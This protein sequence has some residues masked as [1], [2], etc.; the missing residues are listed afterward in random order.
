MSLVLITGEEH[1]DDHSLMHYRTKGSKNG[2]RRFQNE[3]GSLTPEG[4]IHYGVGEGKMSRDSLE[5]E[6]AKDAEKRQRKIEKTGRK[7]ERTSKRITKNTDA[8]EEFR[9]KSEKNE[10]KAN[11]F[12]GKAEAQAMRTALKN[13][14]SIDEARRM[15]MESAKYEQFIHRHSRAL[16]Y[17]HY[18][19]KFRK[20]AERGEKKLAKYRARLMALTPEDRKEELE[21]AGLGDNFFEMLDTLSEKQKAALYVILDDILPDDEE[22]DLNHSDDVLEGVDRCHRHLMHYRTKGSKN[23]VRRYQYEDGSL[24][25]EGRIHYGVGEGRKDGSGE[26]EDVEKKTQESINSFKERRKAKAAEREERKKQAEEERKAARDMSDA[27]LNARIDRLQREKRYADLL[28]ERNAREQSEFSKTVHKLI[29]GAAED[30]A[31]KSLTLVVNKMIDKAKEG[32][33]KD[34]VIDLSEYKDVDIYSLKSDKIAAIAGAFQQ[35]AQLAQNR[36][37][38]ANNGNDQNNQNG[39]NSQNNQGNKNNQNNQG[40]KDNSSD[41]AKQEGQNNEGATVSK[42]QRKK[43][44][45]LASSGMS[46]SEIAEKLGVSES[47]VRQYA[48]E[49]LKKEEEQRT[50]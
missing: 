39:S 19:E 9:K 30:L 13:H 4:R 1:A 21:H 50:A 2:I 31:K 18:S 12:L 7:I 38:I 8:A 41:K 23:G 17:S 44:R 26:E 35:A 14:T 34:S 22:G 5:T 27:D 16:A 29:S 24:T 10:Q 3:D 43:M 20:K 46:A 37:L 42:N 47:T 6:T 49:Q 25:P 28:A 36:R 32:M 40:N 11:R 45:S 15:S 48:G 33:N